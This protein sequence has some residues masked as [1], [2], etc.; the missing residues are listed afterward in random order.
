[1]PF[2]SIMPFRTA[3]IIPALNEEQ[4]LGKVLND[5]PRSLHAD[6]IVVD[7]GSTD[8]TPDVARERGARVVQ[9]AQRGYGA[10]CLAGISALEKPDVVVF[11]D[12]DYSDFPEEMT[13]LVQPILQDNADLVIGSRVTGQR[14]KG[15]LPPHSLFGN[16]LASR[17]LR[18]LFG[19]RVT[20]LGPFR[21]IRYDALEALKMKDRTYGWTVEMQ[22]KAA[23][24]NMRV[25]EVPVSYRKRIGK[26]KITGSIVNS[27][28]AGAKIIG[29]IVGLWLRSRVYGDLRKIRQ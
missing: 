25:V 21:A 2:P 9:Q 17:L 4:S 12:G 28:K 23:L 18:I 8:H 6:V 16:W 3:V 7:N 29:V 10:A 19:L 24:H 27:V 22:A 15:A 26:S 13:L 1:M 11:M 14:E 5:I 20:D